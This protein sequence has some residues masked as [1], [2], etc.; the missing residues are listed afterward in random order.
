M[1]TFVQQRDKTLSLL[2]IH[3]GSEELYPD[4]VAQFLKSYRVL[5]SWARDRK[6][7]KKQLHFDNANMS[8]KESLRGPYKSF[9]LQ[10][11]IR[12]CVNIG[13]NHFQSVALAAAL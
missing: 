5:N 4:F 2:E 13:P 12:L 3:Q 9:N 11:V 8:L 7:L 10:E 6:V 1:E